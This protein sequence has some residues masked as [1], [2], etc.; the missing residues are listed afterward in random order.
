MPTK[1]SRSAK[2]VVKARRGGSRAKASRSPLPS[3]IFANV[4]PHSIGGVSMFEGQNQIRAETVSSFFSSGEIV[5]AAVARLEEAG[6]EILQISPL[7][8]NIAG[9]VSQYRQA[10]G[11][12]IVVQ[13]R[14]GHQGGREKGCGAVSRLA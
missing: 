8:I 1:K 5:H 14:R 10:F 13:D 3:R 4:S 11:T 6:F 2:P 12:D 7:T 9:T